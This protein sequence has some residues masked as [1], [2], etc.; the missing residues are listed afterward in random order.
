MKKIAALA[1]V[2]AIAAA[3]VASADF[4]GVSVVELNLVDGFTTYQ[5]YANFDNPTDSVLAVSATAQALSFNADSMLYQDTSLPG[6]GLH[7]TPAISAIAGPADS[8]VTVGGDFANGMTDT[9]FSPG[10]L[11][12]GAGDLISGSSFTQESNG[13]YFDE[14]PGT[15]ENGGSV[16]IAQFTLANDTTT[17]TYSGGVDWQS[18]GAGFTSTA[19]DAVLVLIPA[20]G[21]FA[22]LG[23]AGLATARRRRG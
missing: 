21:A 23:L 12:G 20:P 11:G 3:S 6:T 10:F 22:L 2:G 9:S 18:A 4:T 7:D 5:V 15:A 17:A 16:I 19:F 13:G 1:G 8:W 14:N